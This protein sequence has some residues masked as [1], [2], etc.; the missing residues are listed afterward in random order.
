VSSPWTWDGIKYDGMNAAYLTLEGIGCRESGDEGEES[1][2]DSLRLS[3]DSS[4]RHKSEES[5]G[6]ILGPSCLRFD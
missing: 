1:N 4:M 2:E 6:D 5:S 3:V